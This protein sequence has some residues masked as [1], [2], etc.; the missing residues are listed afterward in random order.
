MRAFIAG[1]RLILHEKIADQFLEKFIALA[2][3][4]RL[5]N[6]LDPDTEMGPLTSAGHRDRVLSYVQVAKEQGGKILCG[7]KAPDAPEL[8]AGC[9]G[10]GSCGGIVAWTITPASTG[11]GTD[12]GTDGGSGGGTE[13]STEASSGSAAC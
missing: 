5:G 8:R 1:S 2:R 12:G 9:Y 4:I 11:G 10:T 13:P 3:S 6:P 7:G